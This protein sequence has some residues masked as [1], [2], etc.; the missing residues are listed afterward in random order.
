MKDLQSKLG[1]VQSVEPAAYIASI[2]GSSA[3]LQGFNSAAIA[4]NSGLITDGTHTPIVEESD[5]DLNFTAVSAGDLVGTSGNIASSAVQKVGYK[6]TKRYLRVSVTVSGA[7]VGGV[8]TASVV[9]GN[10]DLSPVA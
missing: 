1:L 5:D 8:Y 10:A 7:T 6:G 2:N 9:L 4:V 3:D